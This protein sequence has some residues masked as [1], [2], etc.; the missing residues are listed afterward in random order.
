MRGDDCGD[1]NCCI[2]WHGIDCDNANCGIGWHGCIGDCIG[3]CIGEG[4]GDT[5][6]GIGHGIGCITGDCGMNCGI[7]HGICIGEHGCIRGDDCGDTNCGSCWH[8]IGDAHGDGARR[9]EHCGD[10]NAG[11]CDK[12]RSGTHGWLR[13]TVKLI[14]VTQL[15]LAVGVSSKHKLDRRVGDEQNVDTDRIEPRR[16]S[17]PSNTGISSTAA[18]FGWHVTARELYMNAR[19]RDRDRRRRESRPIGLVRSRRRSLG[20][21]RLSVALELYFDSVAIDLTTVQMREQSSFPIV[22]SG[23]RGA[24]GHS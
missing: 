18:T 6:C 16:S 15:S 9:G 1:T 4:G 20:L 10:W 14:G 5:N 24:C 2:C 19:G 11:S 12:F 23:V 13:P 21:F 22:G 3:D 8:I 17:L 7:W